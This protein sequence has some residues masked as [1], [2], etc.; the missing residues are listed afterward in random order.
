MAILRADLANKEA[1]T[2]YKRGLLRYEPW[3]VFAT[4]ITA[5]AAFFGALGGVIGYLLAQTR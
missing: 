5:S 4:A 1:D 2:E 3:K